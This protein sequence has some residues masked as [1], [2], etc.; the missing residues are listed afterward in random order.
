MNQSIKFES[1]TNYAS[2]TIPISS[3]SNHTTS[4]DLNNN[5]NNNNNNQENDLIEIKDGESFSPLNAVVE[6]LKHNLLP[7]LIVQLFGLIILILYY[8]V[9]PVEEAFNKIAIIKIEYGFIYSAIAT[10]IFG[11]LIPWI[12]IT[13]RSYF[14][15]KDSEDF[16]EK[17]GSVGLNIARL[18]FY[19]ILMVQRGIEVDAFYRLQAIIF[20]DDLTFKTIVLKVLIDQ[21]V[22]T[23]FWSSPFVLFFLMWKD[24]DFNCDTLFK[25]LTWKL[26]REKYVSSLIATWSIWLPATAI[27]YALPSALQVPLFNLILCFAILVLSFVVGPG[28]Q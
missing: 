22:Y 21:F 1:Q 4:N 15:Y 13:V 27:I 26:F 8:T 3:N 24:C 25:K 28:N 19:L 10:S 14:K 16:K 5:N 7:G 18:L 2:V 12:V 9:E 6:G 23:V 20:G 17:F 11:G